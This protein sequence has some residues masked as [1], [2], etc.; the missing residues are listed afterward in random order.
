M[1]S[2]GLQHKQKLAGERVNPLISVQHHKIL[3]GVFFQGLIERVCVHGCIC[4]L[5]LFLEYT[6]LFEAQSQQFCRSAALLSLLTDKD[7]TLAFAML[8]LGDN[9]CGGAA[10]S[11]IRFHL[12]L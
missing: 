11:Q 1:K 2:L 3:I 6:Y 12:T 8:A 4:S 7:S 5:G 9:G 10:D